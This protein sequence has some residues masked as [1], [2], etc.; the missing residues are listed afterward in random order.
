MISS[1]YDAIRFK[2]NAMGMDMGYDSKNVGDTLK[3]STM[4]GMFRKIF[5]SMIGKTFKMTMTP[6]G[7]VTKIEGLA[8]LVQSMSESID[9]PENM[10]EQM[11]KQMASSFNDEQVKQSFTQGFG[12]YPEK[13]VKVGDSWNR[14]LSRD[15]NNMKMNVDVKYTVKEIND[16]SVMLDLTGTIKSAS[17]ADSVSAVKVDMTGDQKGTMEIL[18]SSGLTKQGNIDMNMKMTAMGNPINVKANITI[19][20]K[21]Q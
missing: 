1:T 14:N 10:K 8:E 15:M 7:D 21:E 11:R 16:K 9:V 6:K 2:M 19:E 20:G 4:N 3:E 13:P 12:V 18:R 5:S 17:G